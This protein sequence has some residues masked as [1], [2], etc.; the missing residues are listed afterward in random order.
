MLNKNV[1]ISTANLT[2]IKVGNRKYKVERGAIRMEVVDVRGLK[3]SDFPEN[4]LIEFPDKLKPGAHF[5]AVQGIKALGAELVV[6]L[7]SHP[8]QFLSYEKQAD[9]LKKLILQ[10]WKNKRDVEFLTESVGANGFLVALRVWHSATSLT[11][12]LDWGE[13]EFSAILDRLKNLKVAYRPP[14][15]R[16]H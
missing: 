8:N 12:I 15:L 4:A 5:H 7:R 16:K 6:I 10:R 3:F 13:K 9:F 2:S 14:F 11:E 1:K